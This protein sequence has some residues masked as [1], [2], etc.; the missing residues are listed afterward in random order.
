M[1]P[2]IMLKTAGK[3]QVSTGGKHQFMGRSM[4]AIHHGERLLL[5][6]F[7]RVP[8]GVHVRGGRNCL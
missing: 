1:G 4:A 7:T 2:L 3:Y 6:A 8:A 5:Y